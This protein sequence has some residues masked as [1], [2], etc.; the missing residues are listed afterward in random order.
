MGRAK[1]RPGTVDFYRYHLHLQSLGHSF[2]GKKARRDSP[3]PD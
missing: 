3:L 1:K 2:N